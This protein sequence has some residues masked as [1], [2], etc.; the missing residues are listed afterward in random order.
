[1]FIFNGRKEFFHILREKCRWR[2]K[3]QQKTKALQSLVGLNTKRTGSST[4][5]RGESTAQLH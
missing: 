4:W 2:K 3:E 1:V 5:K